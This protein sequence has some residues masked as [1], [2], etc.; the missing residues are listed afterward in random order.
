MEVNRIVSIIAGFMVMASLGMVHF[1]GQID[2]GKLSWLWLTFFV[3]LN[4]FQM[5][6]T[7]FCPL[8]KVLKVLGLKKGECCTAADSGRTCC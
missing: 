4:V 6:F 3:G 2:L 7:G 5:G 1:M 8:V